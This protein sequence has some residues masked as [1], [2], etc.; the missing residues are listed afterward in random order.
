[1]QISIFNSVGAEAQDTLYW[2]FLESLVILRNHCNC[3]TLNEAKFRH[4]YVYIKT[5]IICFLDCFSDDSTK[6][7]K[8]NR[9]PTNQR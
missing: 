2:G 7:Y 8:M 4:A 1:M 9:H 5:V 6:K 3:S